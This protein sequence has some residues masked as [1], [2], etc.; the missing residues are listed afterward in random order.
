MRLIVNLLRSDR[1]LLLAFEV[2][3]IGHN[4]LAGT[5]IQLLDRHHVHTLLVGPFIVQ[6]TRRKISMAHTLVKQTDVFN[7][8]LSDDIRL[9]CH[10]ELFLLCLRLVIQSSD[11]SLTRLSRLVIRVI[12]CL[13]LGAGVFLCS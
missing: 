12:D 13:F 11:L 4:Y 3:L 7:H 6:L 8:L 1:A 2:A 10:L 5:E 9:A